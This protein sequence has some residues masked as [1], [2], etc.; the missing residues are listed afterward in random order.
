M[1]DW[2]LEIVMRI[3]KQ[4]GL[5]NPGELADYL[6]I[7]DVLSVPV[8]IIHGGIFNTFALPIVLLSSDLSDRRR[9]GCFLHEIF[10]RVLH[11]GMNRLMDDVYI[12]NRSEK[13]ELEAHMGALI[14]AI[15]WDKEGF[16][17]CCYNVYRFA[18]MYGLSQSAAY[19]V[20]KGIQKNGLEI[21]GITPPDPELYTP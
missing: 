15:M 5:L 11:P 21:F 2:I 20:D 17:D 10:H 7:N 19:Y 12:I 8:R 16:E 9:I 4:Y 14:Y 6:E 13:L 18:E 1:F 3:I